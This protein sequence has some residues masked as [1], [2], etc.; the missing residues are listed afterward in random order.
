MSDRYPKGILMPAELTKEIRE[1]KLYYVDHCPMT[2]EDRLFFDN[3]GGSFR[4]KSTHEAFAAVDNLPNCT[5]H[6]GVVSDY[7][8]SMRTKATDALRTM[9]NAQDGCIV[10][11]MTA[12]III[13][14]AIQAVI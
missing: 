12:S 6:G 8:D 1:E 3:S 11:S 7:L 13:W 2:N 5:G 4:L 14:D 10:T 9:F